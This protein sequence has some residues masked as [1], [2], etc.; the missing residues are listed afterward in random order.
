MKVL[1]RPAK[2]LNAIDAPARYWTACQ[3]TLITEEQRV[4]PA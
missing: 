4:F 1:R 3:Q 2:L